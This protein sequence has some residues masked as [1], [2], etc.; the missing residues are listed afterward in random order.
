MF[1]NFTNGKRLLSSVQIF[2]KE[3]CLDASQCV[4]NNG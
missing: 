4:A 1:A 3:P 2:Y